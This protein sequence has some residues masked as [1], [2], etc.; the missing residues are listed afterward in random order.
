MKKAEG[1]K[2]TGAAIEVK[3]VTNEVVEILNFH[4]DEKAKG[5]VLAL[6]KRCDEKV[7]V[8]DGT[9]YE[10]VLISKSLK[11]VAPTRDDISD[12][13]LSLRAHV[14]PAKCVGFLAP[15]SYIRTR[16]RGCLLFAYPL[17]PVGQF[18]PEIN[19]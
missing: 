14:N 5:L 1:G 16:G 6:K 12:F 3:D 10:A 19:L 9:V 8:R 11:T 15:P 18:S 4:G 7:V 13:A 17:V 2:G